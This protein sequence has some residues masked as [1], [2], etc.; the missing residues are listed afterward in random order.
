[1]YLFSLS[2]VFHLLPSIF[3]AHILSSIFSLSLPLSHSLYRRLLSRLQLL[4]A[5]A[6]QGGVLEVF[7][8]CAD[9]NAIVVHELFK[10]LHNEITRYVDGN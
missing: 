3:L 7:R 1:M 9:H 4:W 8:V 2:L 10:W 5:A 6:L